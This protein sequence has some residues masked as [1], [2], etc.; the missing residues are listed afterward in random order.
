MTLLEQL[1]KKY[2]SKHKTD[3]TLQQLEELRN[4]LRTVE[5]CEVSNQGQAIQFLELL[6]KF[7][8]GVAEADK[9]HGDNYPQLL[10]S[11]L[12]VGEDG[13]YSNNLRFIFELI[14]NVDDCEYPSD[15]DHV[16][17][18]NFDFNHN[19]IVLRYNENGFTPFNVFAITGI[20]EAAK[21]VSS[22]KNEIGEKGIGFKSV[23]GV[24]NKVLIRSGWFSFELHKDNFTIPIACY[25][26]DDYCVGTEMTLYVP[27]GKA[28]NI[29][30]E[31]K[32]QYCSKE[33]LFSRNP[34]LFLNKLTRLKLYYDEFRSMEFCVTRTEGENSAK[35]QKEEHVKISVNLN[36]YANGIEK[37]IVEEIEC[38]RYTSSVVFSEA[39]CK[40]RYGNQTKVGKNGGKRMKL[41]VVFPYPDYVKMVGNGAL[42]SF[43]PTQLKFS[44]PVVC[45]VPFKL[46]ASREFVDP[47]DKNQWFRDASKYLSELLDYAY[48]DWAR[49]VKNN[50]IVYLPNY[51]SS[52]FAKN[53][54]KEKCLSEQEKFKG[55]H[56]SGLPIF[57]TIE[58]NFVTA[59]KAV[60]FDR[61]ENIF[62]PE[63]AARLL[64]LTKEFFLFPSIGGN[65]WVGLGVEKDVYKRLFEKAL[66]YPTKMKAVLQYLT[67]AGFV[68]NEDNIP[69][70]E[71]PL[72]VQQI[73]AIMQFEQIERLFVDYAVKGIKKT[74][75]PCFFVAGAPFIS[76][77]EALFEDFKLSETPDAVEKFLT[78]CGEK[79]VLLDIDTEKYFPC[80]NALVLSASDPLS[81][82]SSFC[83]AIDG[84]NA[85]S[86]RMKLREFSNRLNRLSESTEGN[87]EDYL[88]KLRDIRLLNKE[89]IGSGQYKNYI[90]LILKS[91]V[92]HTRFI[93]ELLQNA[94][95][96]EY[97]EGVTPMFVLEN[98]HGK[99]V[100]AYNEVGFT[101]G[102]IRS[103][104]ALGEST[105]NHLIEQNV[106]K[107]GEKGVGFKSVFAVAD[108]VKIHS[109][110]Y[111]FELLAK[112]P[113]IP[114]VLNGD[115]EV[116]QGTRMEIS[117]RKSVSFPSHSD[118]ELLELCLC[119]RNL[120]RIQIN[121]T[122][123]TIEDA[124]DV[125][126]ITINK[127]VHKFKRFI[128]EFT[129]DGA[130]LKE[131]E[132]GL[133]KIS[134]NQR[135]VCYIPDKSSVKDYPL[136]SG[137]PTRHRIKVPLVI[138]A[139]F[140]LTTSREEIEQGSELWNNRIRSEMYKAIISILHLIKYED[141]HRA[142]RL[143]R[144][145]PRRAGKELVYVNDMFNSDYLNQYPF[146]LDVRTAAILPTFDKG[147]F[148][149]A[150]SG[151]AYLYPEVASHLFTSGCFGGISAQSVLDVPR[152]D[153]TSSV[154]N[155]LGCAT[156][157]YSKV[158]PI[159]Q[160]YAG[161]NID[162]E[163]FRVK[164]YD[165]LKIIPDTYC[166]E[167]R[168]LPI[169][170][171]YSEQ[172]NRTEFISWVD[173]AV[174]VKKN[175]AK[176]EHNYYILDEKK[177]SKS[178]CE[179][180]FGVNINEMNAEWERNRYN[181]GLR[182]IVRGNDM[183]AIYNY[184]LHEY[185]IGAFV[186]YQSQDILLGMKEFIPMKN[187]LGEVVDTAVFICNEVKDYFQSNIVLSMMVHDECKRLA[188]FLKYPSLS[189]IHY[190][191][192]P[193]VSSLDDYEIEEFNTDYFENSEEILRNF[194]R[195]GKLSD[196][197]VA[198]FRLEYI[199]MQ[200]SQEDEY[201]EFPQ[202][203][204]KNMGKLKDHIRQ[205]LKNKIE[206]F[207]AVVSR[208][209][210]KGRNVLTGEEFGLDSKSARDQT[211]SI[212]TPEEARGRCFCQMCRKVKPY[213]FMEVNNIIVTPKYYFP[214]TRVA[215]CLEC[216]KS[217]EA[218]R[219]AH[220]RKH[221]EADSF[222]T[223]IL[224]ARIDD[225]GCVD[226]PIGKDTIRFTATHLAEIKEIFK[227]I[228]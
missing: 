119:L 137:L 161:A 52:L 216:S 118:N 57:Y 160:E 90:D 211:L 49:D 86:V 16:L 208:T 92:N 65:G 114:V 58:K 141:R 11:L 32:D 88:K 156:A 194:Y 76:I 13:L 159:L 152:D 72:F 3:I 60:C 197:Q 101:R 71:F 190:K 98:N 104:T 115:G 4:G 183:D 53:N 151:S 105:K 134:S 149:S 23:F 63:R 128:H 95:D 195:E 61:A 219:N 144:F 143:L 27:S 111:H 154:L 188:E 218:I 59:D 96:C 89:A 116:V 30:Q 15:E 138:D 21:N 192:V 84:H 34:L 67:E 9:L 5:P 41:Q 20:A 153:T 29:Y 102:N 77:R 181:D 45:H 55:S 140:M 171:V 221:G 209:I 26:S 212:Y 85:F 210:Y 132:G 178:D 205:L 48:K 180:I 2:G 54:G 199:A 184:L 37:N 33:A 227:S 10:N 169:I 73:E 145:V 14:Q 165:Y 167:L 64:E 187:Q 162:D 51:A 201:L 50:I 91:G 224:E 39:A 97:A 100:T 206:V 176:S 215:L 191:D 223:A 75:R 1:Y 74:K 150:A 203:P 81:S 148:V 217:F 28:E 177:L 19:K 6:R 225:A 36:D 222:V 25:P 147:I 157:P 125:R 108:S 56:F 18:I 135:I 127:R 107:I 42:Y 112:T 12:S 142:L 22:N 130:T 126:T 122:V 38:V 228:G 226:V 109:G 163:A 124:D 121:K 196:E 131:R 7:R 173:D 117:I 189:E 103:I 68:P 175:C 123:I 164:L 172:G 35:V 133:R 179:R 186:K 170:P 31:I 185:S 17:E 66:K 80:K 204:V 106:D 214:Q 220:N 166:S 158:I 120:K 198:Y 146:L 47:Q 94:D 99:I 44:V 79:C 182:T 213:E 193:Y 8:E 62:Q 129:V 155:A 136:Y 174:F 110:E 83:H 200:S 82:F 69:Q 207:P 87:A 78:L 113:T 93:Q 139:P 24:A 46:D 168:E 70:T 202:K 40:A 43:L